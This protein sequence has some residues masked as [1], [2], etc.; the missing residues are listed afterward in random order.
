MCAVADGIMR[1]YTR[2]AYL[3]GKHHR[4]WVR[5]ARSM[6]EHHRRACAECKPGA[7][8]STWN[9]QKPKTITYRMRG[10]V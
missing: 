2:H 4:Y 3:P 9:I 7:E 6:Y 10:T 8:R 5:L 1:M